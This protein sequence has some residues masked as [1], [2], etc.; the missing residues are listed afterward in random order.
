M[1]IMSILLILETM[2][3]ILSIIAS[4]AGV[5][6]GLYRL[7][8]G[9]FDNSDMLG[10]IFLIVSLYIIGVTYYLMEIYSTSQE[11]MYH[12]IVPLNVVFSAFIAIGLILILGKDQHQK[13]S[14][15]IETNKAET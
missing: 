9:K 7:I 6:V 2:L 1:D 5:S 15:K 3:I 12:L 13:E 4:L 8:T 14:N 11:M 10:I